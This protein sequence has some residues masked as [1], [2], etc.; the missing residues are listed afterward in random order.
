MFPPCSK[1]VESCG[2]SYFGEIVGAMLVRC[3]A[4]SMG[5]HVRGE[6]G[7]QEGAIGEVIGRG[8]ANGKGGMSGVQV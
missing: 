4:V 5:D 2:P 1:P 8:D 6:Q 7:W 3:L